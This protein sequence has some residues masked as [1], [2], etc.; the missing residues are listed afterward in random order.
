MRHN[1]SIDPVMK[2]TVGN[3][4]PRNNRVGGANRSGDF[5][6][7]CGA[8]NGDSIFG[9]WFVGQF[10]QGVADGVVDRDDGVSPERNLRACSIHRV[11]K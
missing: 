11:C 3:P 6:K 2:F 8:G 10:G 5:G 1:T 9:H 4:P 7:Y